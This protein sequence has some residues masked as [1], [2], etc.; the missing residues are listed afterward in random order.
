M[1]IRNT[2]VLLSIVLAIGGCSSTG[3]NSMVTRTQY[4]NPTV[5]AYVLSDCTAGFA[6]KSAST[7]ERMAKLMGT[8]EDKVARLYCQRMVEALSSGRISMTDAE[9][10]NSP[11]L[12]PKLRNVLVKQ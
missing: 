11:N 10:I 4:S 3:V 7:H 9:S 6:Y 2:M 1:K 12:S 8:S 5:R